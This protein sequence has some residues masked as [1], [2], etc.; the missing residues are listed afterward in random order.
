MQRLKLVVGIIALA[1]LAIG[2]NLVVLNQN[3]FARVV[4]LA[5]GVGAAACV[6][7][8]ALVLYSI[9]RHSLLEGK[10]L[11]GLNTVVTTVLFLGICIVIY[12]FAEHGDR[13]WDLTKE[14]RRQLA[15]QTIQVL[16][17]LD[18]DVEVVGF[19]LQIDDEL[20]RIAEAKTKR[21]LEQCQSHTAR[22]K[23]EFLDPQLDRL[24]LE[25]LGITH[26]STQGTIVIRCGGAQK[27]IT[28]SGA[29]PRLEERDFTNAVVNLVRSAHPKVCF[30]TGHGERSIDDPDDSG[31]GS[32]LKLLLEGEAYTAER[33]GI[34]I[35][36]P[37]IPADCDILVLNGLAVNGPQGDLHPEEI[38]AIQEYLDRGG[39]LLVMVDPM[40]R[41]SKAKNQVDQLLPWLA[42]RYGIVVGQDIAV[43][44]ETGWT[45]DLT[46]DTSAFSGQ[47][48]ED[49]FRACFN[50]GHRITVDSDQHMLFSVAR[51]VRLSETMPAQV[52]GSELLRT[53]PDFYG[54]ERHR[55]AEDDGQ[56]VPEPERAGGAGAAGGGG[57]GED[58]RTGG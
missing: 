7:W 14:G 41:V 42:M 15:S 54:G 49:P 32:A 27:V 52:V 3:P 57:D 16:E 1:G 34:Q 38:R 20:V 29:S 26:A 53:T 2:L 28:L 19:F 55:D 12:A 45:V 39:R 10:A 4:L 51:S 21:F 24:Q 31:G 40:G 35:T 8:V 36:R 37:E 50:Q 9:S 47:E 43:S 18:K 48:Q 13:S 25:G 46:T 56:G 30:L 6:V 58:G 23:V 33:I 17:N 11:Y 44:E 5:L 22:L